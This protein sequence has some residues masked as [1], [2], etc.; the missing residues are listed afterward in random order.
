[1]SANC[2]V[3]GYGA[4]YSM[5][6]FHAEAIRSVEGLDLTAV[7][8]ADP[9]R[10][11][12]ARNELQV[13]TP[14]TYEQLLADPSIDLVV[15]VT[16]H[17]THAP[18]AVQALRAGKHCATEKPMC[19]SVREADEMISAAQD[20][21][22]TLTVF[23]NR[24]WDSDYLT[25]SNAVK[26][27][28]LGNV[29]LIESTVNG[30]GEPMGWRREKKHGGGNLYDWGAHLWDQ[31]ARLLAPARPARVFADLQHRVWNVDTETQATVMCQFDNGA[32]ATVD[33]GCVSWQSK[34]RWIV[35]GEKA[36]L[37]G[38]WDSATIKGEFGGVR[39]EMQIEMIKGDWKDFYRNLSGAIAGTAE[40]A[41]KP[42]EARTAIQIIEAAV[43]SFESGQ[44]IAI[45]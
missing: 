42:Q 20:T 45:G 37:V 5:G 8:D 36:A 28:L 10:R 39:G 1:M 35:R 21:G 13:D 4:A 9:S 15:L 22:R 7:Y 40:L 18:L 17:D 38:Q 19:M 16:P 2:A 14:E 25:V 41:V 44:A 3:V 33:V 6:K 32:T 11:E 12:A 30:F 24:R 27:G 34:P 43:Q 31:I 29:F 23:H 26:S